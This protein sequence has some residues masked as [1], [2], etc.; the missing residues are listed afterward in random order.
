MYIQKNNPFIKK[1]SPAKK[2][3]SCPAPEAAPTS[4]TGKKKRRGGWKSCKTFG[5][6]VAHVVKQIP[7]VIIPVGVGIALAKGIK[8]KK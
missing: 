2:G 3:E 4:S 5:Q 1:A 6:K 8:K 7:K